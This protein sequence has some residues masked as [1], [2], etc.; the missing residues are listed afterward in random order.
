MLDAA[1]SE[2]DAMPILAHDIETRSVL[3]IADVSTHQYASNPTTDV[4]CVAYSIDGAEP[5][6]WTP[7]DP[8]PPEF[9]TAATD[10]TWV[11]AAHNDAFERLILEHVLV[12][13]HGWPRMPI[14]RRRCTMAAALARALPASLAKLVEALQI[15]QL[16]ANLHN[17]TKE[18]EAHTGK[19]ARPRKPRK[20]EPPGL[21][22]HDDEAS[23]QQHY[24]YCRHDVRL[25][26]AVISLIGFIPPDE[27]AA[28]QLDAAVNQRGI[29][30]DRGLLNASIKMTA[31]LRAA[32]NEDI[33][34]AT[35]GVV[36]TTGQHE[37]LKAWCAEH[38]LELA[39]TQQKTIA[40]LLADDKLKPPL[41][42]VLEL[43]QQGAFIAAAKHNT[44]LVWLQPDDR[45]RHVFPLSWCGNRKSPATACKFTI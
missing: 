33:A 17:K 35:A 36:C 11:V 24:E 29:F 9:I 19:M 12:P 8:T 15:D 10:P 5:H 31:K 34:R 45:V 7:G 27:Q 2:R 32:L 40:A 37:K 39:N 38:G 43:Q 20:G 18:D 6:L 26:D 41:R 25:L 30:V 14:E 23:M 4:W 16:W 42:R 28:W 1:P 22:W 13:K 44:M 21:Y 3:D